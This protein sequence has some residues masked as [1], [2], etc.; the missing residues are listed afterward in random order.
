MPRNDSGTVISHYPLAS[1]LPWPPGGP[2][3]LELEP[4][5]LEEEGGVAL[6]RYQPRAPDSSPRHWVSE[7]PCLHPS[8]H[9]SVHLCL[10]HRVCSGRLSFCWLYHQTFHQFSFN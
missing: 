8:V 2:Q 1:L 5:L 3:T 4:P 6:Q 9:H 7:S 10:S